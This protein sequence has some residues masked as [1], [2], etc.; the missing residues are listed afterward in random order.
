MSNFILYRTEKYDNEVKWN[1]NAWHRLSHEQC[2]KQSVEETKT[3]FGSCWEIR[4]TECIIYEE[5]NWKIHRDRWR[6]VKAE[7]FLLPDDEFSVLS[8][9][10]TKKNRPWESA[11]FSFIFLFL[12]RAFENVRIF[13]WYFGPFEG[14]EN[15]ILFSRKSMLTDNETESQKED[16]NEK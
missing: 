9:N 6:A 1:E 4:S 12:L 11:F 13:I 14:C 15:E 8:L 5:E 10:R 3:K 16:A 7:I 2:S